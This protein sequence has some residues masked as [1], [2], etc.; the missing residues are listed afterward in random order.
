[1]CRANEVPCKK[2]KDCFEAQDNIKATEFGT[3]TG[4]CKEYEGSQGIRTGNY[5]EIQSWCPLE[6]PQNATAREEST[7]AAAANWTI[8]ARVNVDFDELG[9]QLN[10]IPPTATK[11]TLGLNLFTVND[12][13][14]AAGSKFE[15]IAAEGCM[16]VVQFAYNCDF[17]SDDRCEPTI[18]YERIDI[19]DPD[20]ISRGFNYRFQTKSRIRDSAASSVVRRDLWKIRGVYIVFKV[21]GEGGVFDA[22]ATMISLGAGLSFLAIATVICDFL[23]TRC[24]SHKEKYIEAKRRHVE[25]F[26]DTDINFKDIGA[27]LLGRRGSGK[28]TNYSEEA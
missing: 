18:T 27:G 26:E 11:P 22:T 6:P 3:L 13:V 7:V 15:D 19:D 9:I 5:C 4:E 16:I 2:N 17:N 23:M 24:I 12:I 1:V 28:K 20:S 8:F 21:V 25:A 10:N 14:E